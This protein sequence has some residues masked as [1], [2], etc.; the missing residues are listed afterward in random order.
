MRYLVLDLECTCWP[1]NDPNRQK[2]EIIEI[3]AVLLNENYN[4]VEEFTQFVKPFN[5][6][7]LTKYCTDLTSITQKDIDSAPTLREAVDRLKKWM[8]SSKGVVFCSWGYFDKEQLFDECNLSLIDY[9]F[10]DKHINI[11][12]YFSKIMH[13]KK[14]TGLQ[15]ALRILDIQFEGTPHR[16]VFDALMTAKVFKIIMNKERKNDC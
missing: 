5:N 4:Y 7:T 1:K 6:P 16:A 3:G 11:K 12:E 9:P 8:I 10:D 15:K 14:R 2:H 13:R